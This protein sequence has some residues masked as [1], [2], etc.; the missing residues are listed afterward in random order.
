MA[1]TETKNLDPA[2]CNAIAMASLFPKKSLPE[3]YDIKLHQKLT[4]FFV[5]EEN[6]QSEFAKSIGYSP[7]T[8]NM[9]IKGN[10]TG[11]IKKL[12]EKIR[13]QLTLLQLVKN[14]KRTQLA[15][16]ETTVASEILNIANM[17]QLNGEMGVC[18]GSSGLG[19][20]TALKHLKDIRSNVIYVD[21]DENASPRAVLK[22]I[23]EELKVQYYDYILPDE[24]SE[25]I[26]QK[27]KG[28]HYLI[29]VDEAENLRTDVFRVL[30][31]LFDRCE[32]TC[33]LFFVGTERLFGNFQRMKGEF[34]YITNRVALFKSL[35]DL[36]DTDIRQ[37][38]NQVFPNCDELNLKAFKVC[39]KN[40][41][42]RLFNLLKR[43]VD[44]VK[45]A[46]ETLN[47][48]MIEAASGMLL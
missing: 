26:L 15:Y 29:V 13:K 36:K 44:I 38:V 1:E 46:Q 41:A 47:P 11:D 19:K 40:N 14:N 7:T 31:K 9:Y 18:F 30:R 20:T 32:T 42:R 6:E 43:T 35:E 5:P 10:Y 24:F 45:S 8:I 33:G 37:L 48:E 23:A 39:S 21:P 28:K 22:K 16:I 3:D 34:N 17:C 27:L 12:E 25:Q 4:E 2:I